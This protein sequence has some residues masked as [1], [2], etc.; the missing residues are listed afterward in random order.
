MKNGYGIPIYVMDLVLGMWW[1]GDGGVIK[2][3]CVVGFKA[4]R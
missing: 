4:R 3:M 1:K 2:V